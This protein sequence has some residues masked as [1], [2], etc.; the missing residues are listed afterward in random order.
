MEAPLAFPILS[1]NVGRAALLG[2]ANGAP[3]TSGIAKQPVRT[4]AIALGQTNLAGDEQ[5]DLSVHGGPDKAVYA[6]FASHWTF[7]R[8]ALGLESAPVSFGE[9]LTLAEGDEAAVHIG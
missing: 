1:V 3:V 5:A 9:N 7:L 6:Y 4:P 2:A 8:S